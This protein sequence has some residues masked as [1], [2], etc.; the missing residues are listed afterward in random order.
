MITSWAE[1]RGRGSYLKAHSATSSKLLL[2][3]R[4]DRELRIY[5]FAFI[6]HCGSSQAGGLCATAFH[7]I[8]AS[9]STTCSGPR[10]CIPTVHCRS[11]HSSQLWSFFTSHPFQRASQR[12]LTTLRPRV[13]VPGL[14]GFQPGV[15]S[16]CKNCFEE[17]RSLEPK[18]RCLSY[19]PN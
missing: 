7:F 4:R 10:G 16:A 14:A 18:G 19:Q 13:H 6:S 11:L 17:T 5:S 8:H 2:T 1:E 3:G 15:K 12:M 9:S